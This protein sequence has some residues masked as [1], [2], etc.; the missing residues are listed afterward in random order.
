MVYNFYCCAFF[1]GKDITYKLYSLNEHLSGINA[2]RKREK[3][4]PFWART[5]SR[6]MSVDAVNTGT[7]GLVHTDT[8]SKTQRKLP[9]SS[10]ECKFFFKFTQPY[11][12][13]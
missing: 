1:V 2:E 5:H 11:L 7:T 6:S 3:K 9:F 13:V 12:F 8:L 10:T 4:G